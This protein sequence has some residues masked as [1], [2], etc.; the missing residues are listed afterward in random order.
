MAF[1][2][3]ALCIDVRTCVGMADGNT[4]HF[5]SFTVQL[6]DLVVRLAAPELSACSGSRAVWTAA[7]Q[8]S[9]CL[10]MAGG[11]PSACTDTAG[12]MGA[13]RFQFV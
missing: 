9:P 1:H 5:L 7:R 11:I 12:V 8:L 2:V 10:A 3:T 13:A 4:L 6:K